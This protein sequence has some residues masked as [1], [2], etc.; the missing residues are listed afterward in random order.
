[1]LLEL[2]GVFVSELLLEVEVLPGEVTL[3][4]LVLLTLLL[5]PLLVVV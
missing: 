3:P 4:W 5:V 2:E 1:M